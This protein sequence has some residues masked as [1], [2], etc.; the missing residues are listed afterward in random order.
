MTFTGPTVPVPTVTN[1]GCACAS[2]ATPSK[3]GFEQVNIVVPL[4]AC[5]EVRVLQ[6]LR[7]RL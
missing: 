6:V 3:S 7:Q 2:L 5:H 1:P 4:H